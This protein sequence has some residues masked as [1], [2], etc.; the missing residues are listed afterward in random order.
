ME[1]SEEFMKEIKVQRLN[2]DFNAGKLDWELEKSERDPAMRDWLENLNDSLNE[3]L[4]ENLNE[5]LT[6]ERLMNPESL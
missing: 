2:E 6:S 5:S 4:R 1:M 3:I